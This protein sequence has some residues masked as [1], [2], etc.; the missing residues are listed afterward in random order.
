MDSPTWGEIVV[1]GVL[2]AS[3]IYA[4]VTGGFDDDDFC[5]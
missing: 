4:A 2:V 3:L 5:M 1:M